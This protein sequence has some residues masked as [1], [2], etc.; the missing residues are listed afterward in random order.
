M[1]PFE[2]AAQGVAGGFD[3]AAAQVVNDQSSGLRNTLYDALLS[4]PDVSARA[5][6]LGR[7]TG[8]AP[9]LVERNLPEME[10]NTRL[11]QLD[12]L[13]K[14]NPVLA[15]WLADP[16][17]ARLAH[18]DIDTLDLISKS[19]LLRTP[20]VPKLSESY[21][22]SQASRDLRASQQQSETAVGQYV[23]RNMPAS[24]IFGRERTIAEGVT[25]PFMRGLA[26]GRRGIT[27]LM[28]MGGM[29]EGDD[30]G[31]AVRLAQQNRQAEAYPIPENVQAGHQAISEAEGFGDAAWAI[32]THPG[33]VKE[34]VIESMG[35]SA[36]SLVGAAG[37]S[38]LGPGGTAAG[39]GLGSFAV[40]YGATIQDVIAENGVNASD[41]QAIHA[42]LNDPDIMAAAR[43][44]ALAR[45]VPIA[46]F[47][48]LTAGFAGKLLAGVKNTTGSA[49]TRTA[50]ELGIQAGGGGAGEATAQFMTDEFKPGEIL[51][52]AI[53]E[54]PTGLIEI[55]AN[56][57][58]ARDKA[59]RAE[60]QT[61]GIE[62][63]N[64]LAKASKAA[65]R[66][67]ETFQTLIAAAAEDGPVQQVYIDG[68]TLMQSGLAPALVKASP[69]VR[70]QLDRA[71]ITG[72]QIA[73]PV[74][75]YAARIAPTDLAPQLLDHLKTEP[76]GFSRAEAQEYMQNAAPELQAEV[77][78]ILADKQGDDSFKASAEA[79]RGTI[80]AQLDTAARFTP[81]VNDAY[82]A[83]VSDFYAVTAAKLG[84]TPEE[85]YQRYPLK[86]GAENVAGGQQFDQTG[87]LVTDTPAFANWFGESKVKDANG[88]PLVV[89]HGGLKFDSFRDSP[90]SGAHYASE[91]VGVAEGYASQYSE[92]KSEIKPLYIRLENPLDLR[93]EAAFKEWA[94]IDPDDSGSFSEWGRK[95]FMAQSTSAMRSGGTVIEK[96]K[97]AGYDGVIFY[98]TDVQN[99]AYHTSYAFFDPR[100]AKAGSADEARLNDYAVREDQNRGTFDP[101]DP[102]ILNQSANRSLYEKA[103]RMLAGNE[104]I[105]QNPLPDSFDM[106]GA[107]RE[108]DPGMSAVAD[109]PD[110]DEQKAGIAKKWYVKMPDGTHAYVMESQQGEV[111]LDAS[112]LEEGASGGTKLYLL[113]G[114][115]AEGN[116]K[117]FIG[118][119]AGLSDVALIRRTE[120]MLSLALRF[121]KTGFLRPHE[122]QM[123]PDAKQGTVLARV[124][125]P[126]EWVE[127]DDANNIE[128]LIRTSYANTVSL[129]TEIKDVT[130]NFDKQRFEQNGDEFTDEQFKGIIE[131]LPE[132]LRERG[133]S[134][135]LSGGNPGRAGQKAGEFAPIGIATLKRAAITN[136]LARETR[137]GRG[138]D[139]LAGIGRFVSRELTGLTG[140]LYQPDGTA[141]T[142]RGSFSPDTLAITLLKNADLSTFLH[143]SGHFFLEVQADIAA[144]LQHEAKVFGLDALKPGERQILADMDALLGWFGVRGGEAVHLNAKDRVNGA[145]LADMAQRFNM[146][147]SALVAAWKAKPPKPN[148][149]Q[150]LLWSKLDGIPELA[151]FAAEN[152]G[153]VSRMGLETGT[154]LDVWH[155]LTLDEKRSY[156]EQFARGFE[157]YLFEGNAPSIELQ[158]LFQR[159]RAWLLNVYRDLKALNVELSD[160]VRGVFDRMLATNEQIQLAEQG[161]SMMP[162]FTSPEQAG[163]T[164]EEF[165]A[166]QALGV[167][168]TNEAIQDL[169]GR[170][171]RDMQWLHNTRGRVIK[172]LKKASAARR[173]EMQMDAR[174]E[175]MSQ[176]LYRAW[177]FLTRKL[178][179][180]DKLPPLERKSDPDVL[181][182]TLD[183]LFVAI[184]KLGGIRKDQVLSEWG[185]DPK[186]MPQSGLFGKPVW[187]VTD[188]LPIDSMASALAE[189]GYLPLNQ[190]GQYELNDL[191]DRFLEELAGN[192]Q[193]SNAYQP[194]DLQPGE[195]I[196]N[197][198]GLTAGRLDLG[199]LAVMGV[200]DEVVNAVKARKMTAAEGLHPDLAAELYGFSS[201]DELVR[202]LAAAETPK[203]EIDALTDVRMLENYGDLSSPEAIEKAADHAI[204]NDVRARMVATEANALAKATGQRK[205]LA[206]AAREYAAAMIARL[207]VRAIKPGQYANAEVRAARAAEKASKAGDLAAAAAE[208]RNQLVNTYA[209]RAAY[210]A[211]EEVDAGL[212]YLK[213]FD[214]AGKSLDP[215][216]QDQI[217]AMLE[218]FDLR[219][220]SNKAIDRRKSLAQWIEA[221]REAGLEPDIAPELE[222]E[223]N[224]KSYKDMTVEE[225]RGLLDTVKQIEHLGRLK[226][227]LLTV[228]DQRAFGAIVDEVAASIVENGG[229][230]RPVELET[231]TGIR[232]W[233]E[234]FAA[235][236]RKIAS[237]IRQMDG[238]MDNGPFWRVLVRGMNEAATNEAVMNEQ[239]TVA[240]AGIY[241]P[242]LDMKGGIN[243]D[244]QFIPEI[245][246]SL[247]RGGRLSVALNWGNATNRARIMDGDGWSEAQV[248]A[249]L[250][251]L[252]RTEWGFVN[253][254]WAYIDS[255]WPQIEAKE[256]RVTGRAPGK[257]KADPFSFTVDGET[258]QLTGGYYPIK[259]DSNRDDRA[260]KLEAADAA[261]DMMRGAFTR[262]TT[263]RGHTKE[264]VEGVR[265]PVKKT[266][267]VITQ[268]VS[269]VTHDLAWHEWL[270]DANRLLNAK[271][272]NQAI[273]E[274]YGTEVIRT[275]K[276]AMTGIA[277]ADIIPQTKV[278]TA[279]LYL[280]ANVSRST[281]GMSL[282]TAFLQPFGLSQSMVRIGVK[283]VLRGMARWTGDA[284]RFESSMTWISEKS[285]FMRLRNKTFNRELHEIKGRVSKGH[286]QARAIYDA[287]LFMLMQKMQMVA[288]VPTWIGAY[289]KA[290]AADQDDA[291]AVSLADQA[292]L[293]SQGG[294]QTKD[295][296]QFQRK[297]PF[298][299]MFYSYFNTTLNLAAESTAAT[300]FKNPLAVA[301]W[302]SDM[303]LLMVIPALA[304]A[305]I[306]AFMK[307]ESCDDTEECAKKLVQAQAGY[308]L[309]LMLGMR[310]LS[311][312]TSGFD[313]AGPPVGR[314]VTELSRAGTQVAQGEADEALAMSSIS[315]LGV[316]LGIPT[317]QILRSWRGWNAWAEGDAPAASILL[318]PPQKD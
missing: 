180:N 191:G 88:A 20:A 155:N 257:V 289:E 52:E 120:N 158:G 4:N 138:G 297:H 241:K 87:Q 173:A 294:G 298:M 248:E 184:A 312:L 93:D 16:V 224:R 39:A 118:D 53:A 143:E 264:R 316:S 44:K 288:D 83:M 207:K 66:D 254:M 227:K 78:R 314:V 230:A 170:G 23:G 284:A 51:L 243:G 115:Y 279:L 136:T 239:A 307:G 1:D 188:G 18:D 235:G 157:A 90:E 178:T 65:T 167:D 317:T 211:Q 202:A 285:D 152:P 32:L 96:A 229:K 75:E 244:K 156:H 171:L 176:P 60:Q 276:D 80:K 196:N 31:L 296:S 122:Y 267:D 28:G 62:E 34:T 94:G 105:F 107:A 247:T 282:T 139:V 103:W 142:P 206:S 213:K 265:R 137:A 112:R 236:H 21:G 144:T 7:Q 283:P 45:G 5:T 295:M 150:G 145:E 226:H 179:D 263:R 63:L 258:I 38:V 287:S 76:D 209:T 13:P 306:L 261:K 233:L 110:L 177:D 25:E 246:D 223:A 17:N 117:V 6:K 305:M 72:G 273:R 24:E 114:S 181:D 274:H 200:P 55:P 131:R 259:Y 35:I 89:Y 82:S 100:Q 216:Y 147:P 315:L 50:G 256:K 270:I 249:I 186:D 278:D 217:D 98:D 33:A 124:V 10:R 192:T 2:K 86:V 29:Y 299:T 154:A 255:H 210:D 222:N 237:L 293:D 232:P 228:Q 195:Q 129:A 166:Y 301:G 30:A 280:R 128:E 22:F 303:A 309:N 234:G 127:G 189:H 169:Q 174:R 275:M 212:R 286:S 219:R 271:P 77:E 313:Y 58:H 64:N 67:P 163:M 190:H 308:L 272:I 168:A 59:Q 260:E 161:R 252:T 215:E 266:L 116:G 95:A 268:H 12:A 26:R 292:V 111:W 102:N 125:K 57:R 109:K 253:S 19:A 135:I 281:M 208:K 160:E 242:L 101:T 121:G 214:K 104:A 159:F 47:D 318:G 123:N 48:A 9:D 106:E 133:L 113:V 68:K 11:D 302:A 238:L 43:E 99:R 140:T 251:R 92:T 203:A 149:S 8:L 84:I 146:T 27:L 97:A 151:L 70:D 134:K 3:D 36:P 61:K 126:L 205:V 132:L 119:P 42:A 310:E 194:Q 204:H 269:E 108:I 14:Q 49:A 41:P 46:M 71:L 185:V 37:L 85:L 250:R 201:G 153:A 79:V 130:Y 165:A 54:L 240:L 225:F 245:N 300:N 175:V 277:T 262:S 91:D 73:I 187:R 15:A 162:L 56:Y 199:A 81:Q 198:S 164:P 148:S 231:P 40:E 182:P 221:Q 311:G 218:R 220:Q 172:Q 69:A 183:S 193:Y 291:T 74:D 304:P 290:L 197:P 141:A